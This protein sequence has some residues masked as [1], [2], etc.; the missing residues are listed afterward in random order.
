[1]TGTCYV[2]RLTVG[3]GA[4]VRA[5]AGRRLMLMVNGVVTPRREGNHQGE[6]VL[7]ALGS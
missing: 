1:M 5:A 6:P 4:Q 7:Q 2:T 3:P